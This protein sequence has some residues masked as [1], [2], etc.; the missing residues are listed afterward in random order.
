MANPLLE[1]VSSSLDQ[2]TLNQI[3]AQLGASPEVTARAAAAAVPALV[4]ALNQQAATPQGAASLLNALDRDHDGSVLDDLGGLLGGSG[5]LGGLLGG[6]GGL[7]DLL[8][9]GNSGGGLGKALD[10]AGILGH[11]LGG[12]RS[13]V[14][15]KIGQASGLDAGMVGKLLELLAPIVM[16]AL[17]R[18]KSSGSG[19]SLTDILGGA[20]AESNAGLGGM[21]GSLLD[22]DGDGDPTDDIARMGTSILGGLF[23][24]K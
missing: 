8:G 22:R 4:G 12:R 9:G 10:G 6:S 17:A 11:I 24:K 1:I 2:R 20:T 3:A 16:A 23:G 18:A 14:E 5:G 15:N 7:G 21:L 19:G 13:G